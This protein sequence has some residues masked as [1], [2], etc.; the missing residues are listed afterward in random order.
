MIC[1]SGNFASSATID[2]VKRYWNQRPCN[3]KHST[4]PVGTR[5]YFD[6]V[7]ARKYFVESHIP[8]FAQESSCLKRVSNL[9]KSDSK[10]SVCREILLPAT[11]RRYRR[12]SQI[13]PSISS[14][15]SG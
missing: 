10:F 14:I 6:Q 2:D 5:L 13:K 8:K 7:E 15:R 12:S 4:E 1:E 3:I 11:R 9:L